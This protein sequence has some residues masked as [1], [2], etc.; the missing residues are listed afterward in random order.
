[1]EAIWLGLVLTQQTIIQ[2]VQSLIVKYSSKAL[3]TH[4][5]RGRANV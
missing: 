2:T 1:M 3:D 4:K 5:R